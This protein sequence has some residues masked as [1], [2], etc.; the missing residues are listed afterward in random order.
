MQGFNK[1]YPPDFDPNTHG[2]LNSYQGKHALGN[3]AHKIDQGILVVRF[4]LPFNI[5]CGTCENH[6][7]MGVRYNAEKKKIGSYYSTPI[8][9]FR[10]KCHL[11]DGYF[12]IETDPKNTRYVVTSGARQKDEDWDPEENGGYAI[13]DNDP[14]KPPADPLAT[15]EKTTAAQKDLKEVK[16]PRIE[17]LQ[18]LSEKLNAD[19]YTLSVK[20]R[21]RFRQQKRQDAEKQR[22]LGVIKQKYGLADSLLLEEDD[23]QARRAA[24]DAWRRGRAELT[25]LNRTQRKAHIRSSTSLFPS[26]IGTSRP[27]G[28][29]APSPAATSL[30][31]R[32]LAPRKVI[33]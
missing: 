9:S 23:E 15:L 19:P 29:T 7:G 32:L 2:S 16:A 1:Y 25:S 3:R 13:H 30:R 20:A 8:F 17:E 6:I 33:K 27:S 4:E 14:N 11:C 31:A 10:C 21:N 18:G 28:A 5:W 24:Q 22:K 26:S 12:E